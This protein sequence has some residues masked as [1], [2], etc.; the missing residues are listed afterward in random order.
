MWERIK[1]LSILEW[2]LIE[3]IFFTGFWIGNEYIAGLLTVV[4]SPIFGA[5]LAISLIAD[6]LDDSRIGKKFY[7]VMF[8]FTVIPLALYVVFKVVIK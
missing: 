4:L 6:R 3:A 7:W 5:I 2:V 8:L 1:N